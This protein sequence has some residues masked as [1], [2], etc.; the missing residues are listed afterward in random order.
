VQS[1]RTAPGVQPVNA[2]WPATRRW[3]ANTV[4][5]RHIV[6]A[7]FRAR[8][9]RLL[10]GFDRLEASRCQ[11]RT[12][13]GLVHRYYRT[14]FGIEHDFRRIRTVDDFRRLVPIRN[15]A[16]LRRFPVPPLSPSAD[17]ARIAAVTSALA[18]AARERPHGRLFD[19]SFVLLGDDIN[20]PDDP[21][22]V[23]P[24]LVRPFANVR[25]KVTC[26]IGSADRLARY[27]D[28]CRADDRVTPV[29]LLYTPSPG[30]SLERLRSRLSPSVLTLELGFRLEGAVAVEDPRWR[31]LRLLTNHGV[32]FEFV[33]AA[34]RNTPTPARLTVEQV[35]TGT[36][37]ELVITAPG[38]WW[39]CRTGAGIRF[40]ERNPAFI[41]FVPLPPIATAPGTRTPLLTMPPVP[42]SRPRTSGTSVVLPGSSVHIPWSAPAGRE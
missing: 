7:V 14:P 32:F 23:L 21:S 26:L 3:L 41:R 34:E 8:C 20:L 31:A 39:A 40:E 5:A 30:V 15:A 37:Y 27:L 10:A 25:G 24:A 13:L 1:K 11:I 28:V 17:A 4:V 18:I 33:P 22:R 2:S 35:E 6:E 42:Q 19:G 16:E 29:A 9:R 38:G 12:L 36:V